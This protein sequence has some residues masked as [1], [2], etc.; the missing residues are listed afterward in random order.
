MKGTRAITG[1]TMGARK[2]SVG[3]L[4]KPWAGQVKCTGGIPPRQKRRK[5]LH[6]PTLVLLTETACVKEKIPVSITRTPL[7][8]HAKDACERH[9]PGTL[10][11]CIASLERVEVDRLQSAKT[12]SISTSESGYRGSTVHPT[13]AFATSCL[14]LVKKS[15]RLSW[16]SLIHS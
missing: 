7:P 4:G 9:R 11:Y 6:L 12:L 8:S 2:G 3:K 15:V 16:E 10:H 1:V 14:H 13:V 5:G